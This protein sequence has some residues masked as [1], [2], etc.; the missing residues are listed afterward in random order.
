M[1][2]A[3]SRYGA[4]VDV[5][6]MTELMSVSSAINGSKGGMISKYAGPSWGDD[7]GE[8]GKQG[9]VLKYSD[10]YA[11]RDRSRKHALCFPE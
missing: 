2:K 6:R 3:L 8:G 10:K 1:V 9:F 4:V 5:E 11:A 7:G